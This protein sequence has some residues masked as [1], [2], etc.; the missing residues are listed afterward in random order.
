MCTSLS[1]QKRKGR[2]IY[3][4]NQTWITRIYAGSTKRSQYFNR[5]HVLIQNNN[6][7]NT[8][9]ILRVVTNDYKVDSFILCS[10]VLLTECGQT[11]R[12]KFY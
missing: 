4:R 11:D 2:I 6:V 1:F 5:R 8:I 10:S 9:V 3:Y 7:M 12:Q